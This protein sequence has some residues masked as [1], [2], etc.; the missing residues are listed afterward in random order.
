M[1]DKIQRQH[2]LQVR[3]CSVVDPKLV[4]TDPHPDPTLGIF[5]DPSPD[6]TLTTQKV[7]DLSP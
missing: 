3:Y 2:L 6:L 5:S 1:K 4:F 7:T